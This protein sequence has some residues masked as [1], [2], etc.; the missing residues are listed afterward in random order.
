[1]LPDHRARRGV[2][3][4]NG[5]RVTGDIENAIDQRWGILAIAVWR[6]PVPVKRSG[7]SIEGVYITCDGV[8]PAKRDRGRAKWLTPSSDSSR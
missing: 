1:M 8:N 6:L 5:I 3:G 7:I 2:Q 4:V